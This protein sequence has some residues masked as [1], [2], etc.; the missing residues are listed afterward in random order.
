M[1]DNSVIQLL[2]LSTVLYSVAALSR[3]RG[4][5]EA[6]AIAAVKIIELERENDELTDQLI[7]L[8]SKRHP[9][10]WRHTI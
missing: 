1:I 9:S 8:A 3:W 4:R 5:R 6:E 7:A 2:I 10:N